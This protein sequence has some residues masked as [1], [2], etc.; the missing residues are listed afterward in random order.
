MDIGILVTAYELNCQYEWRNG[1]GSDATPPLR[2][3]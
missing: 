3:T 1:N 2:A